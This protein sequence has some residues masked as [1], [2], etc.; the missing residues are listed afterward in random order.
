MTLFE[1]LM[2]LIS[3]GKTE[4][5]ITKTEALF[6]GNRLTEDEYET[7]MAALAPTTNVSE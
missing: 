6:V 2:F 1:T 5:L 3:R 7:L 4:G